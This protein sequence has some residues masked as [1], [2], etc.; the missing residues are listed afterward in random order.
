MIKLI[1]LI[2]VSKGKV[3]RL[4]GGDYLR[5]KIYEEDP[6]HFARLFGDL[7]VDMVHLVDIDGA[8]KGSPQAYH[9]IEAIAGHTGLKIAFAGGLRTDGD[10]LKV[11]ECGA[12][13]ISV[14]TVPVKDKELFTQW[15]FSYGREKVT[16][17]ADEIDDKVVIGGWQRQTD[18]DLFDHI[19]YYYSRSLKYVKVTDVSRDGTMVGPN[20]GLYKKLVD[21]FPNAC[22]VAAGGV[23]S[24]DDIAQLQDLGVF[25]VIFGKGFY[26]GKI[27]VDDLKRFIE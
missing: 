6:V 25:G 15:L 11:W 17:S 5:E 9:V 24:G 13:F 16:L 10:I 4:A 22:I 19:E 20:F 7:G 26:E 2:S 23:R 12:S 27:N 14:A 1:P 21:Q 3:V 8:L 18:I